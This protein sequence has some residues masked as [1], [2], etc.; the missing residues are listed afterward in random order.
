M[1]EE[2]LGI[3]DMAKNLCI[4]PFSGIVKTPTLSS[5]GKCGGLREK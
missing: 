2:R 5:K 3:K 4:K 1:E